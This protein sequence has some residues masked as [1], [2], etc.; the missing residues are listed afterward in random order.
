MDLNLWRN[1]TCFLM[2]VM[3]DLLSYPSKCNTS[4]SGS[5]LAE[6][7]IIIDDPAMVHCFVD[8]EDAVRSK[9]LVP[10]IRS[11]LHTE[12]C[13]QIIRLLQI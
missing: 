11:R 1:G 3:I 2:E 7:S 13:W 4:A 10:P 12:V 9:V 6:M 5:D 8:D